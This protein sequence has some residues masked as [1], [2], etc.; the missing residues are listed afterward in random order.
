MQPSSARTVPA[1][2]T[3]PSTSSALAKIEPI[4]E[5]CAT[6]TSPDS[7]REQRR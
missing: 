3:S 1:T 2:I 6:T 7:K 5:V 4:S